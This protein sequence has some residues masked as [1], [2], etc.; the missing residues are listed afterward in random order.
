M[1]VKVVVY[2]TYIT[3]VSVQGYKMSET[4]Q[5]DTKIVVQI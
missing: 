5:D 4:L 2:G 1:K 3:K